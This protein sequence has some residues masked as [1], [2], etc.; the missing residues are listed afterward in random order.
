MTFRIIVLVITL[1]SMLFGNE[2]IQIK[3][4]NAMQTAVCINAMKKIEDTFGAFSQEYKEINKLCVNYPKYV[5]HFVNHHDRIERLQLFTTRL[6]AKQG[7]VINNVCA[8]DYK[9]E[10]QICYIYMKR[11]LNIKNGHDLANPSQIA[12]TMA[13][14]INFKGATNAISNYGV[15]AEKYK[16][17]VKA[18]IAGDLNAAD[19]AVQA[20]FKQYEQD[21]L[22]ALGLPIPPQMP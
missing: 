14:D 1:M 21:Y 7:A 15:E 13:L 19:R 2:R 16:T 17:F 5:Q 22:D 4:S 12:I 10:K 3:K 18:V 8:N 6:P 20:N 9:G 11:I